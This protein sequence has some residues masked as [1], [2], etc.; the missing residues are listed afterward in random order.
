MK[1]IFLHTVTKSIVFLILPLAY[2]SM[3]S[4]A[5]SGIIAEARKNDLLVWS[6]ITLLLHIIAL[7]VYGVIDERQKKQLEHL[8]RSIEKAPKELNNMGDLLHTFNKV[9]LDNANKLYGMVQNKKGHSDI[10]NWDWMQS[11]G[12]DICDA[13][14]NFIKKIAERGSNFSVSMM[15]KKVKNGVQ[16]YTMMSR[17]S[18]NASHI[19]KAY[20]NFVPETEVLNSYYKKIF[21]ENP[22][23]PKILLNKKEI[24]ENF[25]DINGINYSQYIALPISCKGKIIGLI[26]IVAY[27]ESLVAST[28]SE[29]LRLCDDY[30]VIAQ[31]TILL[32]DKSENIQQIL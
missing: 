21:D 12:D 1:R 31:S 8:E 23:R 19:P 27:D 28:K 24:E 26:Q 17:S 3:F 2:T 7:I 25:V 9:I 15:F 30:F 6:I 10:V 29:L 16:G 22:S 13:I 11:R 14:Y 4:L 18:N 5:I 32:S 20:R